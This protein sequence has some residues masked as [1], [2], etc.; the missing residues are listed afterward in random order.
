MTDFLRRHVL[1]TSMLAAGLAAAALPM[2]ASAA[3]AA[4]P[5][6]PIRVVVSYPAG[7]VSDVVARALGE[8]LA[9]RLGQ[10]VGVDNMAGAG[11]AI[12]L[13]RW[14]RQHPTA[15]TRAF[16]RTAR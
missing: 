10:P 9:A 6:R 8:K 14:P 5:A 7:G 16:R 15:I 13:T 3:D 11:G 4:W 1:V 12:G 2:A